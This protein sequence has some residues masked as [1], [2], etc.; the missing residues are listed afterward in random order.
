MGCSWT[1]TLHL[2]DL[3]CISAPRLCGRRARFGLGPMQEQGMNR[4]YPIFRAV[5]SDL[6]LESS[7]VFRG[8]WA[9][10]LLDRNRES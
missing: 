8:L 9:N 4:D 3:P 6:S 10:S 5:F 2:P 7:R 1:E